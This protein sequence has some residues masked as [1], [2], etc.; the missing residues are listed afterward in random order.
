MVFRIIA[1]ILVIILLFAGLL[2]STKNT[3]I[4]IKEVS[5]KTIDL[6]QT[7]YEKGKPIITDIKEKANNT[8]FLNSEINSDTVQ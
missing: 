4:F 1:I 7:I 3:I 2:F 6:A 8:N 5:I